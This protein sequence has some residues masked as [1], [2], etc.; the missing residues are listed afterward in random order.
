MTLGPFR[1]CGCRHADRIAIGRWTAE[2]SLVVD[3][4]EPE[5]VLARVDDAL[6]QLRE[7]GDVEGDARDLAVVLVEAISES[8]P[9][10]MAVSPARWLA[11]QRK[12]NENLARLPEASPT[13]RLA[14]IGRALESLRRTFRRAARMARWRSRF[15][16]SSR[17]PWLVFAAFSVLLIAAT[18]ILE[19]LGQGRF[20][21]ALLAPAFVIELLFYVC[22]VHVVRAASDTGVGRAAAEQLA[23]TERWLLS[24]RL[25]HGGVLIATDRRL[26]AAGRKLGSGPPRLLWSTAYN[27]IRAVRNPKVRNYTIR[28]RQTNHHGVLRGIWF[29]VLNDYQCDHEEALLAILSR[30]TPAGTLESSTRM[31]PPVYQ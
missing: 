3:L 28:D 24:C 17:V 23:P 14:F 10:E 9:L 2:T 21:I 27:D 26:L 20:T 16:Y 1:V 19:S 7:G 4:R 8:G 6:R 22:L 13:M 25:K 15:G 11:T 31:Q 30:R 12:V 5:G 29:G 18:L